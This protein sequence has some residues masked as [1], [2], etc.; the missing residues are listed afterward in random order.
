MDKTV[1]ST[2]GAAGYPT[3]IGTGTLSPAGLENAQ[4]T[5]AQMS[6]V[7]DIATGQALLANYLAHYTNPDAV[8]LVA[9]FQ[10]QLLDKQQQQLRNPEFNG[11][12]LV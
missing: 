2:I 10:A 4:Y 3:G 7:G 5:V 6:S 9:T 8:A 12:A 1:A 11:G